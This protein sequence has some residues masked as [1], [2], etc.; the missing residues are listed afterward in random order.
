MKMRDFLERQNAILN[1]ESFYCAYSLPT[2][3]T[4]GSIDFIR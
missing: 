3:A 1:A 4:A 2:R